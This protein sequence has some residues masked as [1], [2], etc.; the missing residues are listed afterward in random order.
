MKVKNRL[1]TITI[2]HYCEKARWALDYLDI[3][4][5]EEN[6]APPFHQFYT[7][8]EGGSSVPVLVT[9]NGAYTDS[10]DI[11]E[12]LDRQ[13]E[14]QLYPTDP[15]LRQKVQE[16]EELFD[17]QLGVAVRCWGYFYTMKNPQLV[18]NVW[19]QQVPWWQKIGLKFML[20][21]VFDRL[22]NGYQINEENAKQSLENIRSIFSKVE[23]ILA[24]NNK[25]LVGDRFTAADLTFA[26][27]AAPILRPKNHPFMSGKVKGM[28]IEMLEIVAELRRSVA[29]K[30]ALKLYKEER[31]KKLQTV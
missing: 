21:R 9:E 26:T 13:K 14:G 6:H 3:E 12:Y 11:L 19:A 8:R 20:S 28:P 2:S 31:L 5:I 1:I 17:T 10:T 30:Y 22:K 25:Y 18:E 7:N 24:D 15:S 16:L 27:L 29:G 4:Y 23:Q